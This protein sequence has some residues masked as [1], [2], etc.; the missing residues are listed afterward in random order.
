MTIAPELPPADT[1]EEESPDQAAARELAEVNAALNPC[2]VCGVN[3]HEGPEG[4]AHTFEHCW[5]CGY[6]PKQG[7]AAHVA[8]ASP[9]L[10]PDAL[11][12]HLD[13]FKSD[14]LG[15]IRDALGTGQ[16]PSVTFSDQGQAQSA[17]EVLEQVA[18]APAPAPAAAPPPPAPP[19]ST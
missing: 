6:R 11:K 4:D 13:K 14:L 5:K 9:G 8:L 3:Q 16:A 18:P 1:A 7:V 12:S 17:A 10:T 15:D 2:Q 19:A